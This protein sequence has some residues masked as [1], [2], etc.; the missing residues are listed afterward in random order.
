MFRRL[1][2]VALVP[3]LLAP[4]APAGIIFGRKSD[5]PDPRDRVPELLRVVRGDGDENKRASAAEE[6]RRYDATQYPDIVPT[7]V[8]VLLSDRKPAVR[9]EAAQT[10]G[11]LRPVSSSAGQALEMARDKDPSMRVRVQARSSLLSMHWNGYHGK[12]DEPFN[13]AKEPPLLDPQN[14][15]Q[16]QPPAVS[17]NQPQLPRLT[18]VPQPAPPTV[19]PPQPPPQPPQPQ[20]QPQP[21]QA[22]PEPPPQAVPAPQESTPPVSSR[23]GVQKMPTGPSQPGGGDGPALPPPSE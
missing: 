12:K 17:T 18:P 11:H 14:Q 6:L 21:P 8:N 20:A 7:L 1:L 19:Q 3:L 9:A 4:P 5:K 23:P 16:P 10:L 2:P 13:G 15:P 22:Q